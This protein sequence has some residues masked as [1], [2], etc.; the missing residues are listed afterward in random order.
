MGKG[1][2]RVHFGAYFQH[3]LALRPWENNLTFMVLG[4]LTY[5]MGIMRVPISWSHGDVGVPVG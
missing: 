5:Q 4:F 3:L 2:A 1:M